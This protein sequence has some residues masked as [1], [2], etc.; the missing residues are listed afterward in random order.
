MKSIRH[1]FFSS[2]QSKRG[3]SL[4]VV[5]LFS[6]LFFACSQTNQRLDPRFG[7]CVDAGLSAQVLHPEGPSDPT[8]ADHLP[9]DLAVLIYNKRYVKS[10]T[11]DPEEG[12]DAS[13]E[14]GS[15]D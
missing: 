14:L 7:Q 2:R 5:C 13:S 4:T 15:L 10:M 3:I 8:P 11:E 6:S 9:G 1:P 12:E